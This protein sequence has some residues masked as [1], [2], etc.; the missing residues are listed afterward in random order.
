MI[1]VKFIVCVGS[2]MATFADLWSFGIPDTGVSTGSDS[3][4]S[5]LSVQFVV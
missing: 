3:E 1:A 4:V 2:H 5:D